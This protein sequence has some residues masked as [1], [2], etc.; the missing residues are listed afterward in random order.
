MRFLPVVER[1]LRT[2]ARRGHTYWTR[3]LTVVAAVVISVWVWGWLTADDAPHQRGLML[4]QTIAALAFTYSL[5]AGIGVTADCLS[6]EKR[7]G[8]LGL[9][10]LTDLK[11]YDVVLGKLAATSLNAFF[12]LFSVFP[13]LAIPLLMGALMFSEFWR[14]TLVLTNTLFLSLAA[15]MFVSSISLR[16]RRAMIGTFL[17]ILA[18]TAGPPLIGLIVHLRDQTVPYDASWLLSSALYPWILSF[19]LA[20]KGNPNHFWQAA[21]VTQLAAWS[22]L[23]AAGLIVRRAWQDRPAA[24]RAALRRERW[25]AW[26][27]GHGAGRAGHRR[28]LLEI[29]P[30]LW[31]TGRDRLRPVSVLAAQAGLGLAWLWLYRKQGGELLDPTIYFLTAYVLHT[32]L[33]LWVASEACRPLAEERRHGTLEMLLSTPLTVDEILNGEMLALQRQFGWPVVL[34]LGAD[35]VMLLAGLRDRLWDSSNEWL[36]LFLGIIV[37]LIAD[38]YTL[39]W[40]GFWLSL[41]AKKSARAL[42]GTV[43]RV[44]VLPWAMLVLGLSLLTAL[45]P[46]SAPGD[47]GEMG[48]LWTAFAVALVN[49]AVFYTW[50]RTNLVERF[51][52]VAAQRFQSRTDSDRMPAQVRAPAPAGNPTALAH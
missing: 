39:A 24:G 10:F 37:I 8:T 32:V 1:E 34:A 25:R 43:A 15:G 47:L 16:D 21:A 23:A 44:L 36:V 13:I 48:L 14:M 5:L 26:Q 38:L 17:L 2:A 30:I 4:F 41:T 12:R 22:L 42:L 51:R 27:F 29:N 7:E 46:Q 19:D 20:Y 18:V 9:L 40:V 31:R 52:L 49:D 11:S 3:F 50:A 33:K 6:E 35:A 45:P 28:R